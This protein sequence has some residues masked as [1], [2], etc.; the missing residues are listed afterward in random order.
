[1]FFQAIRPRCGPTTH[2]LAVRSDHPFLDTRTF[3]RALVYGANRELLL[4]QG[5]LRG[6]PLPG[7]R[8]VSGPFQAPV[9]GVELPTYGYDS[10]IEPRP[11]DPRLGMALV[12]LAQGEL[13]AAFEKQKKQAP[14]L[15]P[16]VLGHP[17][18]EMSRIACRGLA[19]DWKK[20]GVDCKLVEFAPGVFD[21]TEHQCDL[22][23]LQ[24]AAWEPVVDA[25]RLFGAGGLAATENPAI[26]LA[27]RE[28]DASR[29]WQAVRQRL[30][31]LHF[32]LHEDETVLPL[33]QTMDHF[34]YRRSLGGMTPG[35]LRLYQDVEQWQASPR[36]ARSQP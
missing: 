27:L 26:Q 4:S 14:K 23:Y 7:F 13:K 30:L 21:D 29:D 5:L 15:T 17:A 35:R 25:R 16:I 18:D 36:L 1:V 34:A 6:T 33:W 2:I 24:L 10:Q 11:Y 12:L 31:T 32:L 20:I 8:V 22:A 3:R 19:K 9:V 28:I